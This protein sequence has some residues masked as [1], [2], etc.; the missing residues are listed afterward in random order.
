[1]ASR[2]IDVMHLGRDRVICAYELD[3][4]VIDPG[5][6]SCIDALLGGLGARHPRAL[7]LTHIHLDHAGAAGVL[8]R[9]FPELRVYVHE[10]GAPH[11]V[12]PERLLDSAR[13]L[14]GEDMHR[15]W[16]EVAPVPERNVTALRGGE[17]VEGFR[18]GYTPGHASHHVSYLH[19][20]TKSAYV[21]DV[22]GVT[23]P[24]SA[25]VLPPTP[26]PDIDLDA[27]DRSLE[28]LLEWAPDRLCLTHFGPVDE[29]E[30]QVH[31]MR[32]GLA[33]F[34]EVARHHGREPF[35]ET[36]GAELR[37]HGVAEDVLERY[38][39][40][41]P[42]DQLWLGLER[43]WRKRAEGAARHMAPGTRGLRS[44]P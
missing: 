9:R 19:Q 28:L 12:D 23:I 31:R 16:G 24:P 29:P 15:L 18:V 1:M 32:E 43:Y 17:E 21:G 7:L 30:R 11:L 22:A 6:A 5:P 33:R 37:A 41:A 25:F 40:A 36:V 38:L 34:G 3:G 4:V 10:L 35:I 39:Q 8:V 20:G 2:R 14:Y 13:R 44:P 27:W 42:P 26:P